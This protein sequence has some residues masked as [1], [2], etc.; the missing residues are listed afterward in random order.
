[1]LKKT[2]TLFV[3][4]FVTTSLVFAQSATQVFEKAPKPVFENLAL[5]K[6][7]PGSNPVLPHSVTAVLIGKMWNAY[8]T[9]GS[10]TNQIFTD[11]F[12]GLISVVHRID[13][14]GAGSGRIVYQGS[15][16]GGQNWTPQIGPMNLAPWVLGRHPN[17]VLSNPTKSTTPGDQTPVAG[18]AELSSSWYWYQFANDQSFGAGT[19]TQYIDST[20]YPGD[21]MFVNTQGHVFASVE[22]ID[23]YVVGSDTVFYTLFVSTDKGA[24]WAKYPLAKNGDVDNYNGMKGFINKNGVG[25]I[26][27]E[28]QQPGSGK[29][30]FAYKKTT[31]DGAT[32]D[33]NWTWVDPFTLPALSGKVHVLN[34]EVDAI[35]D[36]A[37][38]LHFA[39]TFVDTVSG[40]NTG[41]YHVWGQGSNWDAEFVAKVNRTSMSLPGG[42]STLNEVEFATNWDGTIGVLKFCDVPTPTDTLY[43]VFMTPVWGAAKNVQNITN[44]TSVHEKYSQTSAYGYMVDDTTF[45]VDCMYTIFGSGDSNDLTE[46]QL[47]YLSGV[48]FTLQPTSV[49]NPITSPNRF[50]LQQNYPNPFN[51]TTT[52][53]F[54]I[55]EKS[56]VT[57]KVYDMLGREVTTLI[58]EIKNAGTHSVKFAGKDLPSGMYLYTLTAGNYTATKKMML[59]K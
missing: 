29:Y 9:Q 31:D 51:P 34:Y 44:T 22:N 15:D 58:N 11:P 23:P 57:L 18:W 2:F 12:S 24:T 3:M 7:L 48:T 32:W 46:A 30:T 26:V 55:P 5:D 38:N 28:A 47:W 36:G 53:R 14:T 1:M 41:I 6:N 16:D 35:V 25:Y 13:R 54:S 37:G 21:E 8:S 10:Y 33:A 49:D 39:G 40:A 45:R 56:M 20:Y 50:E 59:V 4:L 27:F 43:D 52:I 42:L 17:I 19:F